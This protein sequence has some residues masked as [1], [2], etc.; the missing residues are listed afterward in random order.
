[1]GRLTLFLGATTI[2]AVQAWSR[3]EVQ[4]WF[5]LAFALI[6]GSIPVIK[7]FGESMIALRK[8]SRESLRKDCLEELKR[9][10]QTNRELRAIIRA[11]EHDRDEWKRR[12]DGG[13]R[14]HPQMG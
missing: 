2:L 3:D 9:E 10:K 6:M 8:A 5:I 7:R 12:Y 4:N 14:D 1:M 13:S 11:V